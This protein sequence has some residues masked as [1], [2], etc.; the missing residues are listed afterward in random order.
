VADLKGQLGQFVFSVPGAG[1]L[2]MRVIG[3]NMYMQVPRGARAKLSDGKPWLEL[4]VGD[5][6][7]ARFG[8]SLSQ[9]Q[10]SS[11]M[12]TQYLAYLASVAPGGVVQVGPASI[13]GVATTEY[14]ATID[15]DRAAAHAN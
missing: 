1:T 11:K 14:E 10:N 6:V 12:S 3:P 5:V 15:L 7:Q 8:T 9:L 13:R 2:A 4:N